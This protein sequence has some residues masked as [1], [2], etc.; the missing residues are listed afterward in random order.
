MDTHVCTY[1]YCRRLAPV[2]SSNNS[3]EDT[4]YNWNNTI[5][6]STNINFNFFLIL[7]YI[8]LDFKRNEKIKLKY[9]KETL[10]VTPVPLN[11]H[12][13]LKIIISTI[14]YN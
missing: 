10:L 8:P 4:V 12:N 13:D 3:R 7:Q 1:I 11:N 6:K 2:I 9:F 14:I 5:Y